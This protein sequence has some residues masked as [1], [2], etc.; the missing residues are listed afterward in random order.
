[1]GAVLIYK[2]KAYLY[3]NQKFSTI[4][5]AKAKKYRVGAILSGRSLIPLAFKLPLSLSPEQLAVQV[6][7]KMYNEGG[8]DPNKEYAIDYLSYPLEHENSYYIEA[9]AVPKEK[10]DEEFGEIVKKIGFLDIVFPRFIAYKALYTQKTNENHLIIYIAEDEAFAAIY[11]AGTFIGL[12]SID[13]LM[14]IAKKTG[15]E[16]AKLKTYLAQ[17][18]IVARNYTD[19][20]KHIVDQLLEIFYKNIEKIVYAVNFKR[21]YFGIEKIDRIILDFDGALIEGVNELLQSFGVEGDLHYESLVCCGMSAKESAL[22]VAAEYVEKYDSLDQ[23]LNF[24]LY[25][26]KKP[27]YTLASFAMAMAIFI[28]LLISGGAYGYLLYKESVVDTR[29]AQEKARLARLQARNK[30][31]LSFYKKLQNE[32]KALS[33]QIATLEDEIEVYEETLTTIPFM[34]QA[35]LQRQKMMN[36]IVEA[37]Y[38]Y[39]LSTKSIEQN[40]TK[41]A[42]IDLVSS[43]K[44]RENIARFIDYLLQKQYAR[45]E[46][47]TIKRVG[48]VYESVVRVVK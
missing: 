24:T 16:V 9:F 38:L 11:Q 25:E 47:Q 35:K 14:S 17:K 4:D 37:L 3:E 43:N 48:D 6:E 26:R 21:G 13:S 1:M 22:A 12:R 29:I 41:A 33:Q 42:T 18:G 31:M 44:K 46:T 36:D 7:L 10:L 30:K 15:L 40:G 34:Q 45:V 20:E 39:K 27:I 23:H 2:E 19:D 28:A 5:I 32:K 8:L